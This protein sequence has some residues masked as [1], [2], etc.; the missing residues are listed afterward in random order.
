MK[1]AYLSLPI[2]SASLAL[3]AIADDYTEPPPPRLTGQG[4]SNSQRRVTFTPYPSADQFKMLKT[5][6][7]GLPWLEDLGGSF[8]G[9]AW[10]APDTGN[11]RFYRLRVEALSSNDVLIATLVNRLCYG[12]T[13]E[14]LDRLRASGRELRA[15]GR[16]S[17]FIYLNIADAAAIQLGGRSFSNGMRMASCS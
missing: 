15:I 2:L 4:V 10:T 9:H 8:S 12:P 3:C 14:L 13:P 6:A 11:N 5:D 1:A 17:T 16:R 7:L